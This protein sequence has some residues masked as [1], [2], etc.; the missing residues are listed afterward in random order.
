MSQNSK[1]IGGLVIG[2]I[3]GCGGAYVIL[4]PTLS[5]YSTLQIDFE[6]VE[7]E[8]DD[9]YT[10]ILSLKEDFDDIEVDLLSVQADNLVLL[11]RK[12]SLENE[13]TEL[14][15]EKT[16]LTNEI[17]YLS[18]NWRSLSDDVF[19]FREA[20]NS[21]CFLN[22]SFARVFTSSEI[23]KIADT[24][25]LV[26]RNEEYIWDGL[27]RI[28][29][30]VRDDIEYVW[31]S[32]FPVIGEY[33][34]FE[35]PDFPLICDFK[36]YYRQNIYQDLDFTVEYKQGD[37]DDQAM[38][39]YAMI[40]YYERY[41][42]DEEYAIYLVRMEWDG[43]AHLTVFQPV[44]DGQICIM[45]PAGQYQT[46]TTYGLRGEPARSELNKYQNYWY[47]DYGDI[48]SIK[49]YTIDID[50]GDYTQRFSGSLNGAISYFES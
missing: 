10:E 46:G 17:E 45:D 34:Y 40:N 47:D 9:Q 13:N 35:D 25:E 30:Y 20:L 36:T 26:S 8:K 49:M 37:C 3:I 44:S 7:Q 22:E 50:S 15:N 29:A 21:Y 1:L 32:D 42:L 4:Q 18:K 39:E 24:V 14:T 6:L 11:A 27:N 12:L 16:E 31:D 28:H 19:A 41:I 38:L 5:A 48:L 43:V 33:S 2:L 23:N